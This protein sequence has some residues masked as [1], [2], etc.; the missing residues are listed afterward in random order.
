M[1]NTIAVLLTCHNRKQK[2]LFCLKKLYQSFNYL[3]LYNNYKL[4]VYLTDDGST[5]GTS[6]AVKQNFPH[7]NIIIGNGKLFWNQ[8]MRFAWKA[9]TDKKEYD[10]F[11]WLNDDANIYSKSIFHAINAS[12]EVGNESIICG[13]MQ[14]ENNI[15]T[16]SAYKRIGKHKFEKLLPTNHLQQCEVFN[17]NFVLIP[18]YVFNILGNLDPAFIHSLGD[19]DYG[20]RAAKK[21]IKSFLLPAYMGQCEGNNSII[22]NKKRSLNKKIQSL[23]SPLGNNPIER[24]KFNNRHFGFYFAIKM[25]ILNHLKVVYNG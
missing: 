5:D 14:D 21:N 2:T 3:N 7:V 17:G 8:G 19:F 20:L 12:N 24:F 16:Y 11:L 9:A 22:I 13:A 23:Y 6:I 10:Y 1:K 15:A 25:F 4:E 18:K